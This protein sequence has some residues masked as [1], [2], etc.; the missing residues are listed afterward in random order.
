MPTLVEIAPKVPP[1]HNY[2]GHGFEGGKYQETKDLDVTEIAK[3]LRKELKEKLPGF[4][5]SIRCE[6]FAGGS[7]IRISITKWADGFKW[8]NDDYKKGEEPQYGSPESKLFWSQENNEGKEILETVKQV[9]NQYNFDDSDGMIDYFHVA[10]YLHVD[11]DV[12]HP[13]SS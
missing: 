12:P 7:S 2:T 10:F 4:K 5:F 8:W 3:L 13:F 6:K 1:S 11:N 9:A